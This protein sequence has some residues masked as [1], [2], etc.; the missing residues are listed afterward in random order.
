MDI[1]SARRRIEIWP[2]KWEP[3]SPRSWSIARGRSCCKQQGFL[4]G[5]P[6]ARLT[7]RS[8]RLKPLPELPHSSLTALLMAQHPHP[9]PG[10]IQCQDF[11]LVE[12][13]HVQSKA[14]GHCLRQPTLVLAPCPHVG[15]WV[16][17]R[18]HWEW[19][20]EHILHSLAFLPFGFTPIS[21]SAPP[22]TPLPLLNRTVGENRTEKKK[23]VDWDKCREIVHQL[24]SRTMQAQC[25]ED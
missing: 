25:K 15:F 8:S 6:W 11:S 3:T 4:K 5:W 10:R 17:Q 19:Q 23:K 13:N 2:N 7:K 9:A 21:S 12:V 1:L 20:K 14:L 16:W 22:C 18:E 24:P